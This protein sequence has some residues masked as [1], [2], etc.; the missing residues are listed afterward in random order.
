MAKDGKLPILQG[1]SNYRMWASVF[2]F[3]LLE[4]GIWDIVEG[5]RIEAPDT[6]RSATA[7]AKYVQENAKACRLLSGHV[8]EKIYTRIDGVEDAK[9]IWDRLKRT[10]IA[11]GQEVV[12]AL[13]TEAIQYP[14]V[15]RSQNIPMH[16]R[17]AHISSLV[18]RMLAAATPERDLWE[19]LQ[20]V[21]LLD[22]VPDA[23]EM[24]RQF[25]L[26]K[27]DVRFDDALQMLAQEEASQNAYQPAAITAA[28]DGLSE[29]GT[30]PAMRLAHR[31][32]MALRRTNS[33]KPAMYTGHPTYIKPSH[34]NMD[35]VCYFCD[36][37][38]HIANDCPA[39]K[40][41]KQDQSRRRKRPEKLSMA[42]PVVSSDSEYDGHQVATK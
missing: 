34:R 26:A 27:G 28:A 12:Y 4:E 31:P 42:V 33:P 13:L 23:Y 32:S 7:Q 17:G 29:P 22:S 24:R 30:V 10:C 1:P 16:E 20:T 19:D 3:K 41:W 35:A 18:T 14:G 9:G 6:P 11:T 39:K 21:L 25:I 2:K 38:G 5:I 37:E 8:A 15:S 40:E 36:E